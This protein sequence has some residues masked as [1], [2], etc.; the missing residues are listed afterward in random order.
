MAYNDIYFLASSLYSRSKEDGAALSAI[1][2]MLIKI[3][4]NQRVSDDELDI[5]RELR[6]NLENRT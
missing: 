6:K 3:V 4:T 1:L 2:A 5:I